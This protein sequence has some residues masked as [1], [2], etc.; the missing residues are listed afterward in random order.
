MSA[1]GDLMTSR[2]ESAAETQLRR[3]LERERSG[4]LEAEAIAE[5]ALRDL[6]EKNEALRH[7][8]EERQKLEAAYR[9]SQKMEAM[10]VLAGGV[11]HDFNNL[12]TVINGYSEVLQ[13]RLPA[14]SPLQEMIAQIAAAGE[15]AALLTSQLLAFSRKQLLAPKVLSLNSVVQDVTKLLRRLIGEDVELRLLLDPHLGQLRADPG[16]LGQVLL[17]LAVNAR[18]AM[19][20]GGVLT[21]KTANVEVHQHHRSVLVAAP[22]GRYLM[23]EVADTGCGMDEATRARIFEPFFTTKEDGK[24]TGLGLSTVY[25]IVTQSDGH[26]E[27]A[28]EPGR[29]AA[30]RLYFPIADEATTGRSTSDPLPVLTGSETVLLVEDETAVR[31][32]VRFTLEAQGYHLLEARNGDEAFQLALQHAGEIHL[33]VTDLVMPGMGGRQL[34]ERLKVGRR[35]T[36]V[37][38]VSGYTG[39]VMLRYGGSHGDAALLLQKPF[40]PRDLLVR[41]RQV[42]DRP[43]LV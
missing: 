41:V 38:Y 3:R 9:Q 25:G 13:S 14:H 39:D 43:A 34:A 27:V 22:P 29:G 24:G 15:R 12:L 20:R 35:T 31:E 21:I 5:R 40:T 23:L 33:L 11:A 6:Y 16:Q 26:I 19:P 36:R 42:L 32:L 30:F 28:S 18:D 7:E 8:M 17:N 2:D 37:L 10:G 4:R 1:Q